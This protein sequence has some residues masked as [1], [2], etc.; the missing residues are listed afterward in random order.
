M[1]KLTVC[2]TCGVVIMQDGCCGSETPVF[3]C[4][5]GE[6]YLNS[7]KKKNKIKKDQRGEK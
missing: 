4:P 2:G 7:L 3:Y 5:C 1:Y 6:E